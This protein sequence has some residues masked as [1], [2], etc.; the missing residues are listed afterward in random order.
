[1]PQ[2]ESMANIE[3]PYC[4]YNQ[5]V[6]LAHSELV[7]VVLTSQ[8]FPRT[9]ETAQ[10]HGLL[11][12]ASLHLMVWVAT[13]DLTW[14]DSSLQPLKATHT[15]PEGSYFE[16]MT[17]RI[18]VAKSSNNMNVRVEEASIPKPGDGLP[19]P[20]MSYDSVSPTVT[21]DLQFDSRI[22]PDIW[23]YEAPQNMYAL[24]TQ[25]T[26]Q[27]NLLAENSGLLTQLQVQQH[28]QL[29]QE[30]DRNLLPQMSPIH[31]SGPSSLN[32]SGVP[33][34]VSSHEM[35]V[36]QATNVGVNPDFSAVLNLHDLL[37]FGDASSTSAPSDSPTISGKHLTMPPKPNTGGVINV[38]DLTLNELRPHFNKPM[39]V[40]AKELGVCI[41]LMKKICRRNGLVR[42]PHRRIR[43][44]VNR[45]TS[46]QMIATNAAGAERERF[47]VQIAD[48]REELSAVIQN[49]NE[50]SRKAQVNVPKLVVKTKHFVSQEVNHKLPVDEIIDELVSASDVSAVCRVDKGIKNSTAKKAKK[51]KNKLNVTIKAAIRDKVAGPRVV[52]VQK[53]FD[54]ETFLS[55]KRKSS[56]G[57]HARHPPPIKIP[58]HDELPSMGR[59]RS[60]SVPERKLRG[61]RYEREREISTGSGYSSVRPSTATNR[62]GMRG[63][64]LSILNDSPAKA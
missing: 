12:T 2:V 34:T 1:M 27:I 25:S 32:M 10:E 11:S 57:L 39:A 38:K 40:V 24:W 30:L 54:S 18:A 7:P 44:L 17:S 55:K 52:S 56:F 47:Q 49:P 6:S 59:L 16:I 19:V 37:A 23:S 5:D 31:S 42:W 41:T 45:I 14:P 29:Q 26:Q 51:T 36:Q 15:T 20:N 33:L 35:I 58:R 28:L 60:Q 3:T 50:K 22:I 63:S 4:K 64:I 43:S 9:K 8:N 62:N 61:E 53:L 13:C 21:R 48:M 46:L